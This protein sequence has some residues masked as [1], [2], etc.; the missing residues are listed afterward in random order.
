MR[1]TIVICTHNRAGQLAKTLAKLRDCTRPERC[2]FEVLVVANACSDATT[3]VCRAAEVQM[4]SEPRLGLSIARNRSISAT[5]SDALLWLDDEVTP[6]KDLLLA[7]CEALQMHPHSAFFGGPIRPVLEGYPPHWSESALRIMPFIWSGLDFGSVARDFESSAQMEHPFGTNML[8]R[9]SMLEGGFREDL[10]RRGDGSCLGGEETELFLRLAKSGNTGRWVPGASVE[11]R[12][13]PTRQTLDYVAQYFRA[14][15]V[16]SMLI[17]GSTQDW[18][19]D[20]KLVAVTAL[21]AWHRV[22]GTPDRWLR[23]YGRLNIHIGRRQARRSKIG[24]TTRTK[25]Q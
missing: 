24:T 10:G 8:I 9:R 14:Q 1:I 20:L 7:Y 16:E 17:F 21:F 6:S 11:H 4:I 15:A 22:F 2:H 12:I 23:S 13:E 3:K 25:R 18:F 5:R 19:R